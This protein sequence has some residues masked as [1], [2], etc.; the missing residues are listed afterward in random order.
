MRSVG[1]APLQAIRHILLRQNPVVLCLRARDF[2]RPLG[3]QRPS[4]SFPSQSV[5]GVQD[6]V[7]MD[8][9]HQ[10]RPELVRERWTERS[11]GDGGGRGLLPLR[12]AC[13]VRPMGMMTKTTSGATAARSEASW[14]SGPVSPSRSF[15]SVA[16]SRPK[17]GTR[18]A[19]SPARARRCRVAEGAEV[20]RPPARSSRAWPEAIQEA[21]GQ[22]TLLLHQLVAPLRPSTRG[23]AAEDNMRYDQ[24]TPQTTSAGTLGHCR[25]PRR[26][27]PGVGPGH[28]PSRID[29]AARGG[30]GVMPPSDLVGFL[31]QQLGRGRSS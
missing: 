3:F 6:D 24:T 21:Y 14:T 28:R 19:D 5:T 10:Q 9:L 13:R 27:A 26:P 18:T 20:G 4:P 2:L 30:G 25:G 31:V 17:K 11:H 16:G 29:P 23:A 15:G 7:V 22:G 8:L 12:V 1:V